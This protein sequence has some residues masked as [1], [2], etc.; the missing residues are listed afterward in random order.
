MT[1]LKLPACHPRCP[2]VR[3]TDNSEDMH[4]YGPRYKLPGNDKQNEVNFKV[5]SHVVSMG[6]QGV[7]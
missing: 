4:S 1:L 2:P 3:P 5:Q 7:M 6:T